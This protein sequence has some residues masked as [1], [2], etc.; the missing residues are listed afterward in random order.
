[1]TRAKPNHAYLSISG[2]MVFLEKNLTISIQ[3]DAHNCYFQR[4]CL[5]G[6]PKQRYDIEKM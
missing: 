1:M 2:L 6:Q 4:Q 3:I 5:I